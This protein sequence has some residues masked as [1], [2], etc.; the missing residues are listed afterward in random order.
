MNKNGLKGKVE[1]SKE[2]EEKSSYFKMS[3][4]MCFC[5]S[6]P[7]P[8]FAHLPEKRVRKKKKKRGKW[9]NSFFLS[10]L[11]KANERLC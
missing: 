2:E 3:L 8:S 4:N 1:K 5:H 10:H 9:K 11:S 6:L 7:P